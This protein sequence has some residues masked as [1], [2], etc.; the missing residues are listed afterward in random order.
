MQH[1]PIDDTA[2][3]SQ[4]DYRAQGGRLIFYP[5]QQ[6]IIVP[7]SV[8]GDTYGEIDEQFFI[9]TALDTDNALLVDGVGVGQMGPH[10]ASIKIEGSGIKIG[11]TIS[12]QLDR[13]GSGQSV[14]LEAEA[15]E[16]KK[17]KDD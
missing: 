4:N 12:L 15:K 8:I 17:E 13:D 7:A 14:T 6:T 2:K 16:Q 10:A 3:Q 1:A 5:G 9:T 11:E